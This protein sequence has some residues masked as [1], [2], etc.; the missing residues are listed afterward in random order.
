MLFEAVFMDK[1][2]IGLHKRREL[3][4]FPEEQAPLCVARALPAIVGTLCCSIDHNQQPF[5]KGDVTSRVVVVVASHSGSK[6]ISIFAV[7]AGVK[8]SVAILHVGVALILF[9]V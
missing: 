1:D 6:Q 9:P 4:F 8:S 7:E 3:H 5:A 2:V